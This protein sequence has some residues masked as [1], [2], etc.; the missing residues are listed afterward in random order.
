MIVNAIHRPGNCLFLCRTVQ[1]PVIAVLH[2]ELLQSPQNR[3]T[4]CLPVNGRIMQKCRRLQILLHRCT[5]RCP[6]PLFLTGKHFR[7]RRFIRQIHPAP[8]KSVIFFREFH[9]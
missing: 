1:M 5:Q 9:Q 8:K 7:I 2:P 3:L 6:Q 4:P